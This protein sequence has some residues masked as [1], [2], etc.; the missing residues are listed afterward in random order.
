MIWTHIRSHTV[1]RQQWCPFPPF[2]KSSTQPFLVSSRKAPPLGG[3]ALRD[4]TLSCCVRGRQD[5]L[6][7]SSRPQGASGMSL[8]FCISFSSS[9]ESLD[10]TQP[11]VQST[12]FSLYYR[13]LF[14]KVHSY[15]GFSLVPLSARRLGKASQ[16]HNVTILIPPS[17]H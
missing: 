1:G 17:M 11:I 10:I 2:Y 14:K 13:L 9:R 15:M 16:R 4:E 12:I 8:P 5:I 6:W 7:T 3:Q